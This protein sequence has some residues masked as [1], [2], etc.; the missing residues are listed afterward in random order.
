[1]MLSRRSFVVAAALLLATP[2]FAADPAPYLTPAQI[3][4]TVMLP[5]PP[6]AGS[7]LEQSELSA[8]VAIQK[9]AST[10]RIAL[11]NSD[12]NETVFDMYTR[13]FGAAFTPDK[14]PKAT[15]F[16]LRALSSE[17]DVTAPAKTFFARTRPFLADADIKA[18]VPP[19]KS[20]SYPS[21]HTTR[22]TL[23]A[24]IL[25]AMLPEKADAI[26]ARADQYAESRIIGGMHYPTDIE[27]GRRA[28]TAMAALMF[29]DPA[30]KADFLAAK[31]EVRADLGLAS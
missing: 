26:W 18:L 31:A 3:D 21:G 9:N 25:D 10:D 20:G 15:V 24:I 19:S 16:F 27:A 4:L 7:A 2:V 29:S 17:D 14:L 5:P 12:A 6:P 13:T 30:F 22:V 8:V 1:M 11:A 28:G 23:A